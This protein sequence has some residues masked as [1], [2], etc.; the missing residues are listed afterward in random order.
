M[1]RNQLRRSWQAEA[2]FVKGSGL[3][4][5]SL[6]IEADCRGVVRTT[7]VSNCYT[8][9]KVLQGNGV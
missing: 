3:L 4:R 9:L 6:A 2:V 1:L 8:P 7:A 5:I